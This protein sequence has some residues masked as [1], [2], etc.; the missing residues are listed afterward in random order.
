MRRVCVA[1][2]EKGRLKSVGVS[3]MLSVPVCVPVCV[4]LRTDTSTRTIGI[5]RASR[6]CTCNM[7]PAD[8]IHH[9]PCVGSLP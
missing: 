2:R 7:C 5:P 1:K 4:L 9:A 3:D 6:A 8:T